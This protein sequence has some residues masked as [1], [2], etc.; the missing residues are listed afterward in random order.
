MCAWLPR[1]WLPLLVGLA[2]YVLLAGFSAQL[3]L[4]WLLVWLVTALGIPVLA[5]W[6]S[7][8][9]GRQ[10][11]ALQAELQVALVDGVQGMADLLA[12]GR[13]AARLDQ[14]DRISRSLASAQRRLAN[15]RRAANRPGRAAMSNFGSWLVLALAIPLVS[16]GDL[17][18][19]YLAVLALI[20]L[21]SFEALAP[22]PL[23]AQYLEG[24]LQAARR[25]FE[26]VDAEPAVQDPAEPLPA[27]GRPALEIRHLSFRYDG[28]EA[29]PLA[30]DDISFE[31]PPGGRIAIVG[32][33]GAGK[34]TL[35]S[36]LARFWE[37]E[38]GQ[39]LLDGQDI[40]ALRA[41]GCPALHGGDLAERLSVQRHGVG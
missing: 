35:V 5:R 17:P 28:S 8:R 7:R 39:I 12:F 31:I 19:V 23:A 4:A 3:A 36:L 41:R 2:V 24:N 21:T 10:A 16:D 6:L 33:S 30:L 40:R 20:A 34:S 37:F 38:E 9:S 27:P 15:T 18:G 11:V 32:P 22:L 26:L 13:G 14:V 25:L 29:S 1:R